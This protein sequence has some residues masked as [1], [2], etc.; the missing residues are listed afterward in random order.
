MDYFVT[1]RRCISQSLGKNEMAHANEVIINFVKSGQGK[2]EVQ[3]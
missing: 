1:M 2:R 3:E